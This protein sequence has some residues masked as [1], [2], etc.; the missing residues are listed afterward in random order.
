M[1]EFT[2]TRDL[3]AY[4]R[5]VWRWKWL[6]LACL[7]VPPIAA[8]WLEHG[9]AKTYR[10][11]TLIG[12]NASNV[13]T[14]SGGSFTTSNVTAIA[15]LVTTS[16]VA[17]VAA[18]LMHPRAD[19]GQI[20]GEVS[21]SGDP[22]TN[23][24]TITAEDPNP[25]RAGQIAN[26]FAQAIGL[27]RQSAAVTAIKS[28]ISSIQNQIAHLPPAQSTLSAQLQA[29]VTQLQTALATQGSAAAILQPA[30]PGAL[31]GP[32]TRRV[33]ELGLLIGLL[34]AF[35][36]VVLAENADRRIRT[37]D[38]LE[39]MT[40]LPLLAA[41]APSAFSG[42]LE[43]TREDEEAFN[44][45]RTSLRYFNVDRG[46]RSIVITSP[47]EQDGKTTVATRL[48]ISAASA[49]MHVTLVDADLRRSQVSEKLGLRVR[50][51]LGSV[52]AG[53][54]K[55]AEE[56]VNYPLPAAAGARLT[57]LP[58]GPPP[59]NP[60]ALISSRAME[61]VLEDLETDSELVI[62]DTP[63]ALAVSD[64]MP[65]MSLVSGVVLVARMNR[66]TKAPIS[67]LRRMIESAN[68]E[69]V[70][71]VAT[72]V[73]SGPGYDYYSPKYY[74]HAEEQA[75]RRLGL[76]RRP[77]PR[78]A[79]ADVV[80]QAAAAGRPSAPGKTRATTTGPPDDDSQSVRSDDIAR[81]AVN[82]D[83]AAEIP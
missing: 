53:S 28:Q 70:G 56:L 14:A 20:A 4:L 13:T 10:S 39:R 17:Q 3:R 23:F 59:P 57:V 79:V 49:G 61:R 51:G 64:P 68:G 12:M 75:K 48:A 30:G 43:T 2:G 77:K 81:A 25:V 15:E 45:L 41:I 42:S 78:S 66:S 19:A 54:R 46:L 52:L 38:D 82:L 35:G 40:D 26:A 55:L 37:P 5:I 63:A 9:K 33:V 67:R 7:V 44:M 18:N 8:Y 31:V 50:E 74:T 69:L 6:F 72:G 62:I 22:T 36:A 27:N 29:Q 32:N 60:S 21:A 65:L 24:L 71:I 34:L 80:A 73:S 76:R 58:A 1:P 83:G 47:G 11:S 16:P